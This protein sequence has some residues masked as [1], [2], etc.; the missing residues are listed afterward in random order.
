MQ[1]TKCYE[2]AE[3]KRPKNFHLILSGWREHLVPPK[4][5][6]TSDLI[7][8]EDEVEDKSLICRNEYG[9]FVTCDQCLRCFHA[10]KDFKVYFIKH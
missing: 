4:N 6:A 9:D 3:R 8:S 7:Y 1:F 10:K 5:N 2:Y